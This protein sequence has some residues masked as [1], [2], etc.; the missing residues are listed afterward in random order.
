M[1]EQ[2]VA[3]H[4]QFPLKLPRSMLKRIKPG[5]LSDPVLQQFLPTGAELEKVAG[6][7]ASPLEEHAHNP[8]PGLLHK[9]A[10]RVLLIMT[11]QCVIHCRYCFRRHFDYDANTPGKKGL[12]PA[13]DYIQQDNTIEEV[14][15]SGGDPLNLTDHHL[16]WLLNKLADI[17]H[18][19]T[20][21]F[22][23]RTAVMVPQRITSDFLNILDTQR[24][25]FVFVLHMNHA[26]EIDHDVTIA[27][28]CLRMKALLL[29]QAVLLHGINDTVDAQIA[30][31][32]RLIAIGVVPYYVHLLD[33]VTGA[34]HFDVSES[35]ACS[36]IQ[37]L[38]AA[39]PG[40]AVPTLVR[41]VPGSTSK[42]VVG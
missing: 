20:I 8:H 13:L 41:E 25:Q 11:Q 38:Q 21:R 35:A 22:H 17:P 26:Q 12:E 37:S 30:L 42:Q 32:R 19:K 39:L 18:V 3:A 14:I 10:G 5:D 2:L 1:R 4:Q 40:Y 36:M 15:L 23:T 33:K 31:C 7:V 16:A 27:M 29:N 28:H 9:Y 34:H 24:F 6:Y